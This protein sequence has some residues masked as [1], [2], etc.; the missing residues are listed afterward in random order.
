MDGRETDTG[1][2]GVGGC[3][4]SVWVGVGV[5]VHMDMER[6]RIHIFTVQTKICPTKKIGSDYSFIKFIQQ[7]SGD[8][9]LLCCA[10]FESDGEPLWQ[11]QETVC[12]ALSRLPFLPGPPRLARQPVRPWPEADLHQPPPFQCT[13]LSLLPATSISPRV[14]Q[15]SLLCAPC[16]F[17][18][19]AVCMQQSGGL[20]KM[21]VRTHHAPP[22]CH[23]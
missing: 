11:N 22:V 16:F 4:V 12:R 7:A 23:A 15:P 13:A 18:A 9:F 19:P 21:S 17:S 10:Q 6:E 5:L 14:S 20:S 8:L 1:K 3:V 2:D